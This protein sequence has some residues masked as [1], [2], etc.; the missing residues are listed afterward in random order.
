MIDLSEETVIQKVVEQTGKT[1]DDVRTMIKEKLKQLSGL[2]SEDGAAHIVA[3]DL[4]VQLYKTEGL[5]KVN[6]LTINAKQ[7]TIAAKVIRKYEMREFDKN[8]RK[9]KVANMVVGDDSGR[10]RVVFWNDQV[11][12]FDKLKEDDTIQVK[13]PYVK[14]NNGRI[15]L[16]LNDSSKLDINPSGVTVAAPAAPEREERT[17]KYLKDVQ[18]GDDNI[19]VLGT[20]VQ[21]YDPRFFEVCPECNKRANDNKCVTHGEV[22]PV[23]NYVTTCFLDDGTANVRTTFWKNQTQHLFGVDDAT[24]LSW[25]DDASKVQDPK[26][27]LLGEIVKIVGRV[28]KNE[29]YDR[30]ELTAQLVIKD[31]D[32]AEEMKKLEAGA[33]KSETTPA[34]STPSTETSTAKS[35][36]TPEPATKPVETKPDPVV[37]VAE[38]PA[39]GTQEDREVK[40]EEVK[41]DSGAE[42]AVKEDVI[43]IDDLEDL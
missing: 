10:V 12:L 21:V 40:P 22:S 19:E 1:E 7:A 15:E 43:S 39:P 6:E 31:V 24:I 18:D 23:T 3:N 14:E 32:P 11:D 13:N 34:E 9:G 25:K 36:E 35:T 41:F 5:L 28:K 8:G 27:E 4:G 30:I 2:I 38:E 17:L 16:H 20:I 26:H 37:E 42:V 29:Q 33:A